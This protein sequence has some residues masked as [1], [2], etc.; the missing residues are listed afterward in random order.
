[1]RS[2]SQMF[3]RCFP[4][5]V[6]AFLPVS[7]A[8]A[9]TPTPTGVAVTV[10]DSI[11]GTSPSYLG[12]NEGGA[13]R[14]ADLTDSGAGLYRIWT[15]MGELEYYDDDWVNA[16]Y[17]GWPAYPSSY[18]GRPTIS[19]IKGD[20]NLVPWSVWDDAFTRGRW[21][22]AV[23]FDE[24]LNGCL[25]AGAEPLLVLRT[26][27]PGDTWW[28][29]MPTA[30]DGVAFWDEWWEYCFTVAYWCNVRNSYGV[31]HFQVHNEP[32]LTGQGWTGTQ[33]EYVQLIE[34]AHDALEFAN[35]L[36]GL[37]VY[38]HAPVVSNYASSY[39]SYS[40]SNA[41]SYID[42]VDYHVY[43]KYHDLPTSIQAVR[44]TIAANNPDGVLEP[45]WISE[46]G[47]LDLQYDTLARGLLTA[48]QL[49]QMADGGVEGSALFMLYDWGS[50]E[51]GLIDE[52]TFSPYDSYYA[53]RLMLR[54]LQGGKD[55]LQVDTNDPSSQIMVTR[56]GETAYVIAVEVEKE[57]IVDLSALTGGSGPTSLYE[58][59]ASQKD[60]V[61]GTPPL[62]QGEVSFSAPASAAFC[63]VVP[64]D[65][66]S[67]TPTPTPTPSTTPTP[68]ASPTGT[69]APTGTLTPTS[70]ATPSPTRTP[71]PSP[72]N[73]PT[74]TPF[75]LP[76]TISFQPDWSPPPPG[77]FVDN[78]EGYDPERG[79]GW[80]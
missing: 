20:V 58:Y 64:L 63:L 77:C 52:N 43:D 54:G 15:T 9:Q 32:D 6:L 5:A 71:T 12:G 72:S 13:F 8:A 66:P 59:S 33:A 35:D 70:T 39:L 24:V 25:A 56:D 44:A 74:S 4:A 73:T 48:E 36:A 37:P 10:H 7:P 78:A 29:W 40:L 23:P 75:P 57:I 19:Q 31:C 3:L 1:M 2:I 45:V 11:Q 60:Q 46:W 67:P 34:Y 62:V 14:A 61:S 55:V 27:G 28:D 26:R 80:L 69:L 41:D 51:S 16:G 76:A 47:D 21:T 18:Y 22:S 53:F 65:H 42:V 17:P 50:G 38:L 68:S 49:Y 79:Y 30:P